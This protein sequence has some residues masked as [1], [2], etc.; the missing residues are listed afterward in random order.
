LIV[1]NMNGTAEKTCHG[2]SWLDH[3]KTY[4]GQR[5]NYCVV[6]SCGGRP[7]AGGHVQACGT[8]EEC[9]CHPPVPGMQ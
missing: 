5:T 2:E 6:K 9:L 7:E 4:S 3:W 1:K 8:T